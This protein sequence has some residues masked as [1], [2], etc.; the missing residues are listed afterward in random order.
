MKSCSIKD[1]GRSG[2][3][4]SMLLIASK[5]SSDLTLHGSARMT[6]LRTR[7]DMDAFNVKS[8]VP[9]R[10][11]KLHICSSNMGTWHLSEGILRNLS[12]QHAFVS[13]IPCK[14]PKRISIIPSDADNS[15]RAECQSQPSHL[16]QDQRWTERSPINMIDYCP[17]S[18]QKGRKIK[19]RA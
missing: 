12:A 19:F 11:A 5:F 6:R 4:I 8:A 3:S 14:R 15:C 2:N 7:R 13:S 9:P 18:R 1:C 10:Q 17:P 16:E